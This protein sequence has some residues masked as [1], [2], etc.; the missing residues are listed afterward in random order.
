MNDRPIQD[1]YP[2]DIAVCFGCGRHNPTGLHIQTFWD[3]AEGVC[4]FTPLP[5]H[6]AYPGVV[7]GGLIAS[8]I[9]CHAV[10]TAVAAGYQA[11]GREP[12][13]EPL[14]LYF[15]ARLTVDFLK[16]APVGAEMELRARVTEL[17]ARKAVVACSVFSDGAER[18]RG[19]V[20]AVRAGSIVP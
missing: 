5:Q 8:L 4:R 11:E 6:A 2:D 9:D 7:Y 13:S 10:G 15:T 18:A 19:E 12:G 3:G 1:S 14:I 16:P 17:G 20:T